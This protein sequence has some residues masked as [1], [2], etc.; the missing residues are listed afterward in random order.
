METNLTKNRKLTILFDCD[1]VLGDFKGKYLQTMSHF[2]GQGYAHDAVTHLKIEHAPFH[3]EAEALYE[4]N[5]GKSLKSLVMAEIEKPG[6]CESMAPIWAA[7]EMMP[8]LMEEHDVW[9]VT[10]PWDGSP[11]WGY[12]RRLWLQ[13]HFGFDRNRIILAGGK[14]IMRGDIFVED[15]P[16]HLNSWMDAQV[17]H[18]PVGLLIDHPYNRTDPETKKPVYLL[19]GAHRIHDYALISSVAYDYKNGKKFR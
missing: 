18:G 11:T 3:I 7:K 15:T 4:E 12:E 17:Y 14:H 9:C 16:H 19:T 1:G 10:S 2:T 8:K 13:K 6:W 5:N